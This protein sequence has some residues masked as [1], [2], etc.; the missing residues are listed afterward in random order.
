MSATAQLR[1][2]PQRSALAGLRAYK[3]MVSPLL[4][5]A[6]RYVP[7]CSEY[8]VEAI[9]RFGLLRG[10]WMALCRLGRCHPFHA[11]G[12]DPVPPPRP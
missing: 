5:P 6:C 10:G 9:A 1:S 11:G 8:A 12:F 7:T 3:A 2:L 4:P